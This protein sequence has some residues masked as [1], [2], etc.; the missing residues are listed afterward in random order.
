MQRILSLRVKDSLR[1]SL[2]KAGFLK[3]GS[4]RT[5]DVIREYRNVHR[6]KNLLDNKAILN[7]QVNISP[8]LYFIV[9]ERSGA[10]CE[11]TK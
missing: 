6:K 11:R 5:Y 7:F 10:Q 8:M 1:I 3:H 4:F 9:Q 2:E